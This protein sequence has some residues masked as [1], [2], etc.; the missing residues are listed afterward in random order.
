MDM[1]WFLERAY[2]RALNSGMGKHHP[3][4]NYDPLETFDFYV[5]AIQHD[6][7]QTAYKRDVE[8]QEQRTLE[9]K[10]LKRQEQEEAEESARQKQFKLL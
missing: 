5:M 4:K 8:A 1:M 2:E 3:T 6:G 10:K 9:E 7:L